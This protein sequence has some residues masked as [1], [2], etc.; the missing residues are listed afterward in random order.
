M[1]H[2]GFN[3]NIRHALNYC[4][5]AYVQDSLAQRDVIDTFSFGTI[6]MFCSTISSEAMNRFGLHPFHIELAQLGLDTLF[7]M[8]YGFSYAAKAQTIAIETAQHFNLSAEKTKILGNVV[9][10]AVNVTQDITPLGMLRSTIRLIGKTCGYQCGFWGEKKLA[11]AVD[12]AFTSYIS[13]VI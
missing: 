2:S 6:Y 11:A 10:A 13:P 5:H 12:Q 1:S 9:Y 4:S 7:E 3:D 8:V